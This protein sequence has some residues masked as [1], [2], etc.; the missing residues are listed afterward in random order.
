MEWC[1]YLEYVTKQVQLGPFRW[2]KPIV[3]IAL[4]LQVRD[5]WTVISEMDKLHD[6]L[7]VMNE[8]RLQVIKRRPYCSQL[9]CT[10][11]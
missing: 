8:E 3:S 5:K 6:A 10:L 4:P 11:E 2:G 7:L 1:Q 9:E